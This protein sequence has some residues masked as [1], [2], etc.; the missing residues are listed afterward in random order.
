MCCQREAYC[1]FVTSLRFSDSWPRHQRSRIRTPSLHTARRNA[2]AR[3]PFATPNLRRSFV[4]VAAAP[5]SDERRTTSAP[6]SALVHL[7]RGRASSRRRAFKPRARRA[8]GADF[9]S[10]SA[11]FDSISTSLF[12][13][14]WPTV[15]ALTRFTRCP[16]SREKRLPS[17]DANVATVV[18]CLAT[19]SPSR[20]S[21]VS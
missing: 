3:F 17:P 12:T 19:N 20:V 11:P 14:R 10:S 16:A 15:P 9:S 8:R 21:S 1:S 6:L 18:F 5:A 2:S 7:A 4:L 13:G